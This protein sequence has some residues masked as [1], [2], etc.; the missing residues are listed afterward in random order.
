M[1]L[2]LPVGLVAAIVLNHGF[3]SHESWWVAS[4]FAAVLAGFAGHIIINAAL[5]TGFTAREAGVGMV[6]YLAALLAF[7]AAMILVDEFYA[8]FFL[9]IAIGMTCLVG[10][11]AITMVIRHGTR[12]AF[13]KFD[14]IRNNN[15]RPS[16]QVRRNRSRL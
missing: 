9:T 16:S 3:T 10:A 5:K 8:T 2:W 1:A 15:P 4:G 7:V 12:A 11:V 13:G 14:I 6:L